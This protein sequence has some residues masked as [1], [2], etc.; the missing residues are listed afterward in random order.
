MIVVAGIGD[1]RFGQ[2]NALSRNAAIYPRDIFR[3]GPRNVAKWAAGRDGLIF[4]AHPAK[5][6]LGA[7]LV[8]WRVL[9]IHKGGADWT[10]S[11]QG[12]ELE[13]CATRIRGVGTEA[14]CA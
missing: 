2:R 3:R 5:P 9:R 11:E 6:Q 12:L 8:I 13:R 10:V 7:P 1:Q 14:A 4:P